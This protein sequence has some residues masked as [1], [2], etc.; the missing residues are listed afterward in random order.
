M[1]N[2]YYSDPKRKEILIHV[3]TWMNL[4]GIMLS[5]MSQDPK[6]LMSYVSTQMRYL[7]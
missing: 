3:T 7:V 5:E 1:M 4:K 6:G 2:E